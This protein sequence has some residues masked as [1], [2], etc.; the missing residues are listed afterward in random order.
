MITI[1]PQP[2][3]KAEARQ[4]AK[5]TMH[6]CANVLIASYTADLSS[7][8]ESA[9]RHDVRRDIELGFWGALL[10]SETALTK[11]EYIEF[12]K[13]AFDEANG[14]LHLIHH[15]SFNTLEEN[16]EVARR[17]TEAGA[18][19]VLLSYPPSFYPA[20]SED[21]YHYTKTFCDA[22][23]VGVILFPVPLWGFDRLH[24][25]EIDP[26]IIRRLVDDVPNVV[27]VKAEGGMCLG[28]FVQLWHMLGDEIVVTHPLEEEAIPLS[29]LVPMQ[30]IG[31]SGMEY[32]GNSVPKMFN[33]VRAGE[34]DK[35]MD[36]YWQIQPARKAG[37]RATHI[38]GA[39]F[40]NRYAWKYMA[41]LNGFNG[42]PL[43]VPTMRIVPSQMRGL[44]QGLEE[45]GLSV[46]A[47][48][49]DAFFVGRNPRR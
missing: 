46:T 39:N 47:D 30:W 31:T 40:I 24:S 44:R 1:G 29:N 38:P 20:T 34:F 14:Q 16:I 48:A 33:L 9:I 23:D 41:W 15:A 42:G 6:G 43:R 18:S 25:A 4:W 2:Y 12:T 11:D 19:L 36:L 5:D 27:A 3:T 45:S 7:L 26:R 28:S 10:V 32:L 8:N 13:C 17:A 49:D 21:I 22:V 35:A 37:A